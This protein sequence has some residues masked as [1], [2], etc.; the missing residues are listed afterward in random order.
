M[1]DSPR[2]DCRGDTL[3]SGL[4]GMRLLLGS[5]GSKSR[6]KAFEGGKIFPDMLRGACF[7]LYSRREELQ[8]ERW[9][10][11]LKLDVMFD[12]ENIILHDGRWYSGEAKF[13]P[14]ASAAAA[15]Q[16]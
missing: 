2:G 16:N 9:H 12:V 5:I 11:W 1:I 14:L 6:T 3:L 13:L 8:S 7:K 4:R 15:H 10:A